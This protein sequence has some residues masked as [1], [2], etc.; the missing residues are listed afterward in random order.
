MFNVKN[1]NLWLDL[2]DVVAADVKR[3]ES[4]VTEFPE[5]VFVY[6]EVFSSY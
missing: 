6:S 3:A 5:V 4:E 2:E 1:F